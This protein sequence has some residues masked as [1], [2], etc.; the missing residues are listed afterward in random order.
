[1]ADTMNLYAESD[2]N[3]IG[4]DSTPTLTLDNTS[5]GVGIQGRGTSAPGV[6]GA[7]LGAGNATV[8]AIRSINSAASGPAFEFLGGSI[9]STAS[10]SATLTAAVRVKFGDV[11][12]WIAV[13][14]DHA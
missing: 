8:A 1:M 13:H 14:T 4:D 10:A 11:Y 2:R 3:I 12:G 6:V 5:T 7:V 9:I